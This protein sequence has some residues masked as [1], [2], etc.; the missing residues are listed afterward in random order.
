MINKDEWTERLASSEHELAR[1]R[2]LRRAIEQY[3]ERAVSERA[4]AEGVAAAEL[5]VSGEAAEDMAALED[6][7]DEARREH[8]AALFRR[9]IITT[10]RLRKDAPEE[11]E[12]NTVDQTSV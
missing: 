9:N 8:D 10:L 6:L 4:A 1:A 7:L 11:K 5:L 2:A 12:Q 3:Y